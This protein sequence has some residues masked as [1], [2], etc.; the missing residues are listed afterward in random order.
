[1][2]QALEAMSHRRTANHHTSFHPQHVASSVNRE[3]EVGQDQPGD[4]KLPE[5]ENITAS[6]DATDNFA[7]PPS[8]R[9]RPSKKRQIIEHYRA[10]MTRVGDIARAV[11]SPPSYVAR[12]LTEAGLLSGYFDLYTTSAETMNLYSFFSRGIVRFKTM[13]AARAS[14]QRLDRLYRQYAERRDRAGQHHVETMALVG[15]NRAL[16]CGKR[17]EAKVFASWL[18]ERL[19]EAG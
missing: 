5:G 9:P 8:R 2:K 15:F 17:A 12:V 19:K 16:S 3:A 13:E 7:M 1:M 18:I 14:V 6:A 11:Q 4:L 10:G